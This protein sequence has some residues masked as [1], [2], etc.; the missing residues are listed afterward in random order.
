MPRTFIDDNFG[1]YDI[2]DEGDVDFYHDVQCRSVLKHCAGCG[3]KV[4]LL[5]EYSYCD[6]CATRIERGFDL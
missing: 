6:S 4:K 3:R 1:T 5:P 2:E